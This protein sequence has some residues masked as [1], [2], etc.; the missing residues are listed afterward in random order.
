MKS[1]VSL[2]LCGCTDLFIVGWPLF[3][4]FS[5]GNQA[6]SLPPS[7]HGPLPKGV[8]MVWRWW[9]PSIII[10]PVQTWLGKEEGG[11]KLIMSLPL[12]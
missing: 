11:T 9:P 4:P 2:A 8:C 6:K 3:F 1:V 7:L 5:G 12:V 10:F